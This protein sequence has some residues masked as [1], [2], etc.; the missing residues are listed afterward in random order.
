[1]TPQGKGKLG[2]NP[3]VDIEALSKSAYRTFE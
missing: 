1:M 2:N 3:F